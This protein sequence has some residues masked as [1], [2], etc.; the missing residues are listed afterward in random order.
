MTKALYAKMTI[1]HQIVQRQTPADTQQQFTHHLFDPYQFP[2]QDNGGLI[3][4]LTAFFAARL[5]FG[6]ARILLFGGRFGLADP[7]LGFVT[8]NLLDTDRISVPLLH[9]HQ[10]QRKKGYA[11]IVL[12]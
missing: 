6:A 12:P 4:V 7:F 10:R 3:L 1:H 8:H 9:A 5:S 2:D 11:G